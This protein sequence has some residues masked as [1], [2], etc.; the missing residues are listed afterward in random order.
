MEID[1]LPEHSEKDVE[2]AL[3][4]KVALD[5]SLGVEDLFRCVVNSAVGKALLRR[6]G[7]AADAKAGD[8]SVQFKTLAAAAKKFSVQ[9]EGTAGFENAQVT[10]G[11]VPMQELDENLMSRKQKGLYI[12]GE[13]ADVDG[14]CGGYNLQWAFSSGAAAADAIAKDL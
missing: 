3:R 2:N 9:I 14:E 4:E 8:G 12:V 11:G 5:P 13:L 10:K 6:C 1:F 7:I